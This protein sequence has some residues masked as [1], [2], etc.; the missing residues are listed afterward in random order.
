MLNQLTSIS[1][2]IIP[3]HIFVSSILLAWLLFYVL[4]YSFVKPPTKTAKLTSPFVT[5]TSV[6]LIISF[7][8]Y[9]YLFL[10]RHDVNNYH[11]PNLIILIIMLF[12]L[13]II[14]II[15]D[16]M[17]MMA[18]KSDSGI[19]RELIVQ[20]TKKNSIDLFGNITVFTGIY[21]TIVYSSFDLQNS[22]YFRVTG[23]IFCAFNIFKVIKYRFYDD[24]FLRALGGN[25]SS[26]LGLSSNAATNLLQG[27]FNV[28]LRAYFYVAISF[29]CIYTIMIGGD[30]KTAGSFFNISNAGESGNVFLDFIYFSVVT[31]STVGFGDISPK[32]AAAKLLCIAEILFG[33]FFLS[34]LIATILGRFSEK[35]SR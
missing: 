8:F 9:L 13:Q 14:R 26:Y 32:A 27:L 31:I 28:L 4:K 12:A 15:F 30:Y 25:R 19:T 17:D 3:I 2:P 7:T 35:E 23:Y 10:R 6:V 29:G 24:L 21:T 18:S 11:A 34:M 20:L 1:I 22:S 16:V 5:V 33:F